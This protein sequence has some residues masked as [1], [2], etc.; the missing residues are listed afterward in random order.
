MGKTRKN[1]KFS[2]AN[3]FNPQHSKCQPGNNEL[4]E[5]NDIGE[6]L[7]QRIANNLKSGKFL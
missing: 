2:K 6:D 3:P 7:L 4:E 1:R 5:H